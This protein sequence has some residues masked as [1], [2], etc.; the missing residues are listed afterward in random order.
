MLNI[1]QSLQHTLHS[2]PVSISLQSS[3][4][5]EWWISLTPFMGGNSRAQRLNWFFQGHTYMYD[6]DNTLSHVPITD[7]KVIPLSYSA[8]QE[9]IYME[10][11]HTH[12]YIWE[13]GKDEKNEKQIYR[14][15]SHHS[16]HSPNAYND[17][18]QA[19]GSLRARN[20]MSF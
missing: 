15:S 2:F 17:G 8:M 11:I 16:G 6:F 10:F 18:T 20:S 12:S 7:T 9:Y 4:L 3:K 14:E 13:G 19:G 1:C 5:P